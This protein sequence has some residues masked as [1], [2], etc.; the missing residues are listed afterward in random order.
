M[1]KCLEITDIVCLVAA[2]AVNLERSSAIS[3]ACTCKA[4]EAAVMEI[5][6]SSHQTDL[7]NLLR[8]FPSEVWEMRESDSGKQHFVRDPSL[9]LDTR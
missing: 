6:W 5:L 9:S 1:H 8:C 3:F 7:V 2:E 4:F